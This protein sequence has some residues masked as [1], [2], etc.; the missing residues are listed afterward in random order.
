[1]SRYEVKVQKVLAREALRL[2]SEVLTPLLP[3]PFSRTGAVRASV[4]GIKGGGW[5]GLASMEGKHLQGNLSIQ[6]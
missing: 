5:V 2:N 3:S 6:T 1:M 4:G